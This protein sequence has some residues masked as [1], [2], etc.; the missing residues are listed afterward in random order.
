MKAVDI[1]GK[2]ISGDEVIP[3]LVEIELIGE[4][5]DTF[6]KIR[7][8]LTRIGVAS[9]RLKNTLYQSVHI[10]HKKGKYYLLSYKTLFVLDGR[11]NGLTIGDIAR[12]NRIIQLLEDW[13]LIKVKKPE[14]ISDLMCSLHNIKIVKFE[15]KKNWKLERKYALRKKLI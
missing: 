5:S 9:Q 3:Y 11:E 15:D 1:I 10:L 12:Q 4:E 14:M 2:K 8:T 7:E 6:L 13:G